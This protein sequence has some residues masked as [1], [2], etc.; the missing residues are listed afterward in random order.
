[1]ANENPSRACDD[2]G[3]KDRHHINC[4][5]FLALVRQPRAASSGSDSLNVAAVLTELKPPT[6][7]YQGSRSDRHPVKKLLCVKKSSAW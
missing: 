2:P 6:L 3:A 5:A 4:F 1:M 7:L